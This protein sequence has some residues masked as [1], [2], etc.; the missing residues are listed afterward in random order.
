MATKKPSG[1]KAS[2]TESASKGSTKKTENTKTDNRQNSTK[3]AKQKGKPK[4]DASA[5]VEGTAKTSGGVRPATSPAKL[6]ERAEEDMTKLLESLNTQMTAAMHAFTEL[7]ASHRGKH[8][9]VIRTKPLDRATAMFQ[10]LVTEV[11]DERVGEILPIIVALRVEMGQRASMLDGAADAE[12]RVE[13]FIRGSEMLDQ[14]LA[15]VDVHAYEPHVGSAFDPLIH[16]AVGE[17]HRDDLANDVVCEVLQAGYRSAR[18]KVI[19]AARVKVN[20]R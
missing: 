14:V 15:N 20:R 1:K 2:T 6:L 7:A 12:S 18:G 19:Y 4:Q 17:T 5:P 10:R 16:L 9:A 3:P 13:F 8:E 11:L